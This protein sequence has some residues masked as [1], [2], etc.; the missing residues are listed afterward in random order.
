M[1]WSPEPEPVVKEE[2]SRNERDQEQEH[3]HDD[4]PDDPTALL[5]DYQELINKCSMSWTTPE[6]ISMRLLDALLEKSV[7]VVQEFLNDDENLALIRDLPPANQSWFNQERSV[8]EV[9]SLSVILRDIPGKGMVQDMNQ[10]DL[11]EVLEEVASTMN[12]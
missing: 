2:S 12:L 3:P 5:S 1:P 8:T 11:F 6:I 7:S 10:V 9:Q 4:V